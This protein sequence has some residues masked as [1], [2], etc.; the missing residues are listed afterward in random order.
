[1]AAFHAPAGP[2]RNCLVDDTVV[3]HDVA[4]A[5]GASGREGGRAGQVR[6][7]Q[8]I[9]E[10]KASRSGRGLDALLVATSVLPGVVEVQQPTTNTAAFGT[11]VMIACMAVRAAACTSAGRHD[12]SF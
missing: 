7:V 11:A 12:L 10:R 9:D 5:V 6:R 3:G 1:L 2:A 4:C 8:E